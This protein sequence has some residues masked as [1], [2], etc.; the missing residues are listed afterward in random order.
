MMALEKQAVAT[1]GR[2]DFCLTAREKQV[3]VLVAAGYTNRDIAQEFGVSEQT[4][5][6]HIANIFDKL[7]VSNRLELLLF[8]LHHRLIDC[9][10]AASELHRTPRKLDHPYLRDAEDSVTHLI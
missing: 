5:K 6:H 8:A 4:I 1:A 2:N 9:V 10:P 3:V 7:G